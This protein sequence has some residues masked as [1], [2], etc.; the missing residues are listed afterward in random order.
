[1]TAFEVF[2][3]ERRIATAGVGT[4]GVLSAHVTWVGGPRGPKKKPS[5]DLFLAVGGLVSPA[6]E[7]VRWMQRPLRVGDEVRFRVVSREKVDKPRKRVHRDRAQ[8]LREKKR[9]VRRVAKELG[10]TIRTR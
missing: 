9:Y 2:L 5:D 3:N 10:W 1:M 4:D 6:D 8:E 7:H